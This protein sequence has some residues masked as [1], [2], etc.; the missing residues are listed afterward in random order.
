LTLLDGRTLAGVVETI[1]P[2]GIVLG[3]GKDAVPFYEVQELRF[4][5]SEAARPPQKEPDWDF[6]PLVT[7]RGGGQVTA[8]L[9]EVRGGVAR[10]RLVAAGSRGAAKSAESNPESNTEINSEI[11]V[12]RENLA[13]FRLREALASDSLFEDDLA[14]PAPDQDTLY[15]RRAGLLRVACTLREVADELVHVEIDGKPRSIRR[16]LVQGAIL[17][18]IASRA[19]EPDPPAVFELPGL[20]SVPAYLVGIEAGEAS[21]GARLLVRLPGAPAATV[22]RL[23]LKSV[24]R[25]VFASQR[26]VFL[27]TLEPSAVEETPVVGT[28]PFRWR[29]DRSASGEALR[30]DG[31]EFRRGLGVHSRCALE[32]KLDGKFRTFAAVIG[33]D[34]AS[35]GRGSVT[36]RVSAD[37]KEIFHQ[38]MEGK[39]KP[40]PLSLPVEGVQLLRLE[41]DYGKDQ[42]DFADHADWADARLTR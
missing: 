22:Q 6:H 20:G 40:L 21:L 13:A 2:E 32:Y 24:E 9:V 42:L 18:P 34:E 31:R 17:A 39:A 35:R 16:Q 19:V 3:G 7:F 36:F 38:A 25:V 29:K 5:P 41:V 10:L 11:T 33:L 8:R 27:S 23:P 14:K 4:G 12:P 1:S 26:V 15:V 28:A 37:G 30:L